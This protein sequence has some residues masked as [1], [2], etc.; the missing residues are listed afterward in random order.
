MCNIVVLY[1]YNM[2][3][4]T[5]QHDNIGRYLRKWKTSVWIRLGGSIKRP[6]KFRL[7]R[8]SILAMGCLLWN[9][10]VMSS[11]KKANGVCYGIINLNRFLSF[12]RLKFVLLKRERCCSHV[13]AKRYTSHE[14]YFILERSLMAFRINILSC[15]LSIAQLPALIF[16]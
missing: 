1:F 4:E 15:L 5:F 9:K 13:M 7:H 6:M 14:T 16:I 3:V 12:F 2:E 11:K 8:S 10:I